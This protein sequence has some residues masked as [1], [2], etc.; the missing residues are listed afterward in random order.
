MHDINQ[1]KD[2]KNVYEL[3][4]SDLQR[5]QCLLFI[6]R[7]GKYYSDDDDDDKTHFIHIPRE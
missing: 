4:F 3:F 2:I 7:D 5:L 1:R 6:N